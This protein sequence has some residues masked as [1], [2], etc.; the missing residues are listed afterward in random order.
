MKTEAHPE[1]QRTLAALA[2]LDDRDPLHVP[3]IAGFVLLWDSPCPEICMAEDNGYDLVKLRG[4]GDTAAGTVAMAETQ[5][6]LSS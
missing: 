2:D 4:A 3:S 5:C 6:G 1:K